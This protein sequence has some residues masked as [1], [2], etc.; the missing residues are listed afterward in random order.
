MNGELVLRSV[1]ASASAVPEKAWRS[2]REGSAESARD[3]VKGHL[4]KEHGVEAPGTEQGSGNP[5]GHKSRGD[6]GRQG[7]VVGGSVCL[8]ERPRSLTSQAGLELMLGTSTPPA[9]WIQRDLQECLGLARCSWRRVRQGGSS[10]AGIGRVG[11]WHVG[12]DAGRC[13][14]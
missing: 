10:S 14:V 11:H 5:R 8:G 6:G 1:S 9:G 3:S 12:A 2:W 7:Q 4:W 13:A